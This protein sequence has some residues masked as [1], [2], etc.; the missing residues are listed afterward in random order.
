MTDS[1]VF[2][3]RSRMPADLLMPRQLSPAVE[4]ALRNV[5]GWRNRPAPIDVYMAIRDALAEEQKRES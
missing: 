1:G 2:A 4:R 5:L 3:Y